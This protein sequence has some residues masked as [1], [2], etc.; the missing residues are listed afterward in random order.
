MSAVL[1]HP[2]QGSSQA[3]AWHPPLY[4][5]CPAHWLELTASFLCLSAHPGLPAPHD[6]ALSPAE[7]ASSSG[8]WCVGPTPTVWGSVRG[9]SRIRSRPAA[10]LPAEVSQVGWG[11]ASFSGLDLI[12]ALP[13]VWPRPGHSASLEGT[14]VVVLPSVLPQRWNEMTSKDSLCGTRCA[15][16]RGLVQVRCV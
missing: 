3:E 15:S 11:L 2:G 7:R 13:A 9:P 8:R 6:S 14:Q 16:C 12:L 1:V 4:P 10:C 5:F